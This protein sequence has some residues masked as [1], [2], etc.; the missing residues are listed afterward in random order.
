MSANHERDGETEPETQSEEPADC[1]EGILT[2]NLREGS[3]LVEGSTNGQKWSHLNSGILGN[4]V[5]RRQH[6]RTRG[7]ETTLFRMFPGLTEQ[8]TQLIHWR[9]CKVVGFN[10]I[11]EGGK[12]S[13][14]YPRT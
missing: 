13:P 1:P 7:I 10:L 14:V 11:G 9:L 6:K 4:G 3:V 2:L 5:S 12:E 8:D